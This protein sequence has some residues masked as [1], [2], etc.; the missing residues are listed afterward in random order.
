MRDS[1]L[2]MPDFLRSLRSDQTKIIAPASTQA[3]IFTDRTRG[4]C[5]RHGK[6]PTRRFPPLLGR[7]LTAPPTGSTGPATTHY[8]LGYDARKKQN[9]EEN[10][11]YA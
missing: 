8:V 7:H 2:P 4:S 10:T 3:I 6:R 11:Q 5:R 9:M 1:T